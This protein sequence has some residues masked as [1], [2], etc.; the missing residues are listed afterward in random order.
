M[1]QPNGSVADGLGSSASSNY[2]PK[3]IVSADPPSDVGKRLAR[4]GA[5]SV[6]MPHCTVQ[7]VRKLSEVNQHVVR[8]ER[9]V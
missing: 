9:Y 8:Q 2:N 6:L 7:L 3:C 5:I 4:A 1:Q